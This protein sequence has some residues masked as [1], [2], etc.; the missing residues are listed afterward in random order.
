MYVCM[1]IYIYIYRERERCTYVYLS[2]G[3]LS[4]F[5]MLSYVALHL[6]VCCTDRR[7][8]SV[9]TKNPETIM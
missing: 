1:Y 7:P 4:F 2:N 9:A 6:R 8:D 3:L 5:K